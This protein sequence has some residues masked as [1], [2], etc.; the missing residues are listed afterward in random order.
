MWIELTCCIQLVLAIWKEK[1][2]RKTKTYLW[3]SVSHWD[4]V[5]TQFEL[6]LWMELILCKLASMFSFLV[7]V[8]FCFLFKVFCSLCFY[9]FAPLSSQGEAIDFYLASKCNWWMNSKKLHFYE[10]FFLFV[11]RKNAG[12]QS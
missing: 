12:R 4:V 8:F 7:V 1:R 5:K 3:V 11:L 10:L 2:R 6:I 9:M